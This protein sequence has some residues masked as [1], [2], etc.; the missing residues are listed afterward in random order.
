[1]VFFNAG[2]V[3]AADCDE[4]KSVTNGAPLVSLHSLHGLLSFRCHS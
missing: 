3:C 2:T 4:G 1:M